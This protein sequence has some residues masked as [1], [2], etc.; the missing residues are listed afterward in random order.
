MGSSVVLCPDPRSKW[1]EERNIFIY[2]IY[3][4]LIRRPGDWSGM[5]RREID[6]YLAQLGVASALKHSCS[7]FCV[8]APIRDTGLVQ[9]LTC[10]RMVHYSLL[11]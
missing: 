9:L 5:I 7:V 1:R 4:F 11:V 8:A 2:R 6:P 3:S 10:S